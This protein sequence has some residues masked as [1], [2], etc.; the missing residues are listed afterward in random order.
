MNSVIRTCLTCQNVIKNGNLK[1]CSFVCRRKNKIV[2]CKNCDKEFTVKP[3]S[4]RVYCSWKCVAHARKPR[5][6][7]KDTL[8][9][10]LLKYRH[11]ER[12]NY[13]AIA[14][15]FN[16]RNGVLVAK[17]AKAYGV[18]DS[19]YNGPII[20]GVSLPVPK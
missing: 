14:R 9:E 8:V 20:K 3:Y 5:A 1:Y 15:L 17:W 18:V 7:D 11:G 4:A 12:P 10:C 6:I 19:N 2:I 16:L 13:S